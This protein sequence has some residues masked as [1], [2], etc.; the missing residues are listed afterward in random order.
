MTAGEVRTLPRRLRGSA[1]VFVWAATA[2]AAF[3]EVGPE[4]VN[5][6][7]E[8]Y[9][10]VCL[11]WE[12]E[13]AASR[14][15]AQM[16][17]AL[18]QFPN[19]PIAQGYHAAAGL[20]LANHGWSPLSKWQAFTR[21]R[22]QLEQAIRQAPSAADLRLIRLGVQR[23][24]PGFLGYSG[25]IRTDTQLCKSA[26]EKGHWAAQPSFEQFVRKTLS[27]PAP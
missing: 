21:Y 16:E 22:D 18:K 3:A 6:W 11:D 19:S 1:L 9:R 23:H 14:Y 24:A 4:P 13:E 25:Q 27:T 26:L 7:R 20:I 12:R 5:A 10:Q 2:M 17:K 15:F 8:G